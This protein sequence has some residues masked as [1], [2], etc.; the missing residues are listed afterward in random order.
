MNP[1]AHTT[2]RLR[3]RRPHLEADLGPS[4]TFSVDCWWAP[5]GAVPGQTVRSDCRLATAEPYSVIPRSLLE[6]VQMRV[7][8]LPAPIEPTWRGI[9]CLVGHVMFALTTQDGPPRRAFSMLVLVPE[10]DPP[11]V[12]G[13][14]LLGNSFL[15]EQQAR[16]RLQF[17][18]PVCPDGELLIPWRGPAGQPI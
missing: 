14:V 16:V 5:E 13:S 1:P 3:A 15:V 2:T 9:P 10:T 18:G 8:A 17:Q 6:I 11:D 4:V 7:T 12:P